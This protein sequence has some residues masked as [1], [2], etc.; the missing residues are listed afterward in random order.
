MYEALHDA[1]H[2]LQAA[3]A[4]GFE[5]FIQGLISRLTGRRFFLARGGHQRGKDA[6]TGAFGGTYVDIECK[7]YSRGESPPLRDL[8]GGLQEAIDSSDGLLDLWLVVSTGSIGSAAAESLRQVGLRSAVAVEII[9]WQDAELPQLAILCAASPQET[10]VGLSAR[11]CAEVVEAISSDLDA[12]RSEAAFGA[13]LDE[14]RRRLDSANLGFDHAREAANAWIRIRL[15]TK[16]DAMADFGQ[17]L[18]VGDASFQPY[19]ERVEPQTALDT[20]R[21]AWGTGRMLCAVLGLEG[22]GKSWVTLGWWSR[23]ASPPL[24]LLITSNRDFKGDGSALVSSALQRQTGTGDEAFWRRHIEQWLRRPVSD[25]PL[26]LVIIDGLNERP[27]EGWD[28]LFATF[29]SSEWA[30]HVAVLVTCRPGF[31]SEYVAPCLP[32]RTTTIHVRPFSDAELE[33]AWGERQPRLSSFPENVRDFIRTPRM[34]RLAR[35]HV[36]QLAESGDLTVERLLFEDWADRRQL[37]GG[38]SHSSVEVQRLVEN[39]ARDLRK[40]ITDFGRHKL[41]D[42]SSLALRSPDRDLDKDFDEI[43][44]GQLFERIST[45]SDR[46]RVRR[47]HAGLVLGMLLAREVKDAWERDGP[48]GVAKVLVEAIEPIGDVDQVGSALRGACAVACLSAMYPGEARVL[49]LRSWLSRPNLDAEHW[50]DFAAYLPTEPESF[51]RV[52]ES[53]WGTDDVHPVAREWVADAIL[54]WR[55]ASRVR[56]TIVDRC[57]EWLGLWHPDWSLSRWPADSE[58]TK[59]ERE[60]IARNEARLAHPECRLPRALVAKTEQP[61]VPQIARLALLLISHGPRLPHVQGLVAWALSRAIMERADELELVAWCLCLNSEDHEE[62]AAAILHQVGLILED[63]SELGMRAARF[64]LLTVGSPAAEERL[65]G[66]PAPPRLE[67]SFRQHPLDVD[68]LDPEAPGPQN[69]GLVLDGLETLDPSRLWKFLGHT[70]EDHAFESIEPTLARYAPGELGEYYRKLLQTAQTRE[71]MALRQLGW[72][73]PRHLLLIGADEAAALDQARRRLL[74]LLDAGPG[75]ARATEAFLLTGIVGQ[76][77][78]EEQLDLLLERPPTAL[79][80]DRVDEVTAAMPDGLAN[81]RLRS[82]EAQ[83]ATHQLRR[84]LWILGR[85]PFGLSESGRGALVRCFRHPEALVRA[86]AFRVAEV[87]GDRHSLESHAASG[88]RAPAEDTTVEAFYGSRALLSSGAVDY[89]SLRG[90]IAPELLGYAALRDGT[91]RAIEAYG[92]DLNALWVTMSHPPIADTTLSAASLLRA[93]PDGDALPR[94]ES[95]GIRPLVEAAWR[96]VRVL[97][98]GPSAD[99]IGRFF[100]SQ[101]PDAL[102]QRQQDLNEWARTLIADAKRAGYRLFGRGIPIH[103]LDKVIEGR[104]DLVESWV[105]GLMRQEVL[106][107]DV[108]EFGLG[109]CSVLGFRDPDRASELCIHLSHA[110]SGLRFN[111]R[112][113][114]VDSLTWLLFKLPSTPR[115]DS[116]REVMVGEATTDELLAQIAFAA[117]ATGAGDWLERTIRRD[118]EGPEVFRLAR[119]LTLLGH[120]DEGPALDSLRVALEGR[121]G[122]LA[123]VATRSQERSERN[124]RA[125]FWFQQFL[126]RRDR[127]EAWA[128]FRLCLRCVDRRFG[129]WGDYLRDTGSE[130]PPLWQQHLNLNTEE[131]WQ[132]AEKNEG[133]LED[134]LFGVRI[135]KGEIV[136]WY[137]S[138]EAVTPGHI[139]SS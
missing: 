22:T 116:A 37:K 135:S 85:R 53:L 20:W 94:L 137:R 126:A 36:Q 106:T 15:A 96:T 134:T 41:R 123:N 28:S 98:R 52:A 82:V 44:D 9:D 108:A 104:P 72:H 59:R 5:G 8:L 24:T 99:D 109:L 133:R 81:E 55:G 26:V 114:N 77:S 115:V 119:G 23:L 4:S 32:D 129:V 117:Q 35:H 62:T 84:L 18:C 54:R 1:L 47:E 49:L 67:M 34:L 65:A 61:F 89:V 17:A 71:G 42:Y 29:A 33:E 27:R 14:L 30:G 130:L 38:L 107:P 91:P 110:L 103:G 97:G 127:V 90:R 68:P 102:I 87:C 92:E 45:G 79:D 95:V 10:L 19:V 7:R 13:L 73:V 11:G 56:A 21:Q 39:L 25:G 58:R 125:R 124:R 76:R 60:A 120:L 136:P 80:L 75:D 138:P 83:G 2:G 78:A 139:P 100:S 48:V 46:F 31:W 132:A 16:R 63:G 51:F 122:F 12:I 121:T 118:L 40:G 66:L 6:S 74:P 112:P 86:G 69:V 128:A 3:G 64:L 113:T 88:W 111:Y 43:I 57:R 70:A 50:Q 105:T 131:I 101:T 93:E